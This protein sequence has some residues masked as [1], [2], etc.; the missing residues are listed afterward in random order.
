MIYL[1][2]HGQTEFNREDRVQGRIDSPLTE[3]GLAQARAIGERLK[4]IKAQAGG[5]WRVDAS[6][7]GRAQHTARIVAEIAGLPAPRTDPRLIEVDY[8]QLEGMTRAEVDACFPRLAGVTGVFG[9]APGGETLEALL[10]RVGG[11]LSEAQAEAAE[12]H[13]VAVAHVGVIRALRGLHLGLD[14]AAMR[15]LDKPQDVIFR[16][17]DGAVE[18]FDCQ[19]EA[20]PSTAPRR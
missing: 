17:A 5:A 8:G 20:L 10:A 4:A 18:R 1:I 12:S 7:L 6:P 19:V 13:I 14:A 16:L 3:L 2:R 15:A 9:Q 11:W